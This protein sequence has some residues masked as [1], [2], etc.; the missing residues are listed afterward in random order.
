MA[1]HCENRGP[2]SRIIRTRFFDQFI[3]AVLIIPLPAVVNLPSIQNGKGFN[4]D[5]LLS[6]FIRLDF[7]QFTRILDAVG[8]E[9]AVSLASDVEK[10][11]EFIDGEGS[12]NALTREV[13]YPLQFSRLRMNSKPDNTVPPRWGISLRRVAVR[14]VEKTPVGCHVQLGRRER[15]RH[16]VAD[17]LL[18]A[19]RVGVLL[20]RGEGDAR[21]DEEQADNLGQ[22]R[23]LAV[24]DGV[25]ERREHRLARLD[26]LAEADRARG[27]S[28]DAAG[29]GAGGA[30][31][32]RQ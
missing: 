7:G 1:T 30:E 11:A 23:L 3:P 12:R 14:E 20:E 16:L 25:H 18:E 8:S 17:G 28:E 9:S 2:L 6:H 22:A 29:V 32:D 4:P 21:H 26:D 27:Q 31:R 19:V 15:G 5:R 10:L 24:E 13:A